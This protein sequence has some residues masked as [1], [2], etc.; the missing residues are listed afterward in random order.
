MGEL[1]NTSANAKG[2]AGVNVKT[3]TPG[4]TQP[5]AELIKKARMR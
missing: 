4:A 2:M 1:V 5:L 3:S